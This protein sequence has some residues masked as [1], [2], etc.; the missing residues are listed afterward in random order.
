LPSLHGIRRTPSSLL[1]G[2]FDH[3]KEGMNDDALN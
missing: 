1:S 2:R 3:A